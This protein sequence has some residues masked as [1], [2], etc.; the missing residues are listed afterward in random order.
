MPIPG[1]VPHADPFFRRSLDVV[2][3]P[4]HPRSV[5]LPASIQTRL[6]YNAAFSRGLFV[7][8]MLNQRMPGKND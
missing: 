4:N 5:R 3:Q 6:M 8:D 1:S 7:Y 2:L